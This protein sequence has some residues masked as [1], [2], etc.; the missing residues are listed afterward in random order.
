MTGLADIAAA[1]AGQGLGIAGAFHAEEGDGA[2]E[3]V[4]TVVLLGFAPGGWDVF[5]GSA[6]AADGGADPLD[7]WSARVVGA[8]AER[9][10]AAALFPFGGPPY[11][12]F[13]RWAQ[14]GEGARP[15][16]VGMMVSPTRGLWMSYRGALG[17]AGRLA[18]EDA[19]GADP[20]LGCPAPCLTAC[21]VGAM[22]EAPYDVPACT[23]HV[24]SRKGTACREIGCLVRHSCPAGRDVTPGREQTGFHMT[25]FL[26]A[27]GSLD[28]NS[29]SD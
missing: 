10:G 21:P 15:S 19:P 25:A 8:L 12:P 18:L 11:S 22:G 13:L 5:S 16:P 14:R 28:A 20:C 17:L 1:A 2:P 23:A 4:G 24:E 6:E 7:R 3:G 27:H 9:L 29:P 26:R